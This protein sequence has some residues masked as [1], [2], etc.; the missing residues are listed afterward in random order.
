MRDAYASSEESNHLLSNFTPEDEETEVEVEEE[1]TAEKSAKED[2][3]ETSRT[4]DHNA[5]TE[6]VAFAYG[7]ESECLLLY[8]KKFMVKKTRILSEEKRKAHSSARDGRSQLADPLTKQEGLRQVLMSGKADIAFQSF[9][10]L[11]TIFQTVSVIGT[12]V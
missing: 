2:A 11:H 7:K 5:E 6:D 1:T 4:E 8:L 10:I 12:N 9:S 3:A